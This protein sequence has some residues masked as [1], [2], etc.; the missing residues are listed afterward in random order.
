[1]ALIKACVVSFA[2]SAVW[3]AFEWIQFKEL[4]WDRQCDNVV[5]VLYLIALWY[6][7]SQAR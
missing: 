4:Q 6:A 1:M 2:I 5:F 3:Y 7:F